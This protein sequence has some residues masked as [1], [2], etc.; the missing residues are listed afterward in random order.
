VSP[1]VEFVV[2]RNIFLP[3]L[4]L[5]FESTVGSGIVK[6]PERAPLSFDIKLPPNSPTLSDSQAQTK[7]Q[8][9]MVK[10]LG[11]SAQFLNEIN[12]NT[13]KS[14]TSIGGKLLNKTLLDQ[15]SRTFAIAGVPQY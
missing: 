4:H 12:S 5:G 3:V 10:L 6:E 9:Q 13:A 7:I 11:V 15:A 2:K 1:L 14:G 8:V